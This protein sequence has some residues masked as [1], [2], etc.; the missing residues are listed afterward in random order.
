VWQ[1]EVPVDSKWTDRFDATYFASDGRF[2]AHYD[3]FSLFE[4]ALATAEK[5]FEQHTRA[6]RTLR[7]RQYEVGVVLQSG[8][9][10]VRARRAQAWS[11]AFTFFLKKELEYKRFCATIEQLTDVA[12]RVARFFDRTAHTE[13]LV[14]GANDNLAPLLPAMKRIVANV[15]EYVLEDASA[16]AD[17]AEATRLTT[18]VKE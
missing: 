2:S 3:R 17:A 15:E 11:T 4:A 1:C 6:S 8:E 9:L 12:D 13:E 5:Q 7:G 18:I 16:I 14:R 10:L